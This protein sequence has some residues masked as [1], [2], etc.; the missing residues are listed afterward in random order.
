VA[1]MRSDVRERHAGDAVLLTTRPCATSVVTAG[2]KRHN[3]LDEASLEMDDWPQ[4]I[5]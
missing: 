4:S 3:R 2:G 1:L 5:G